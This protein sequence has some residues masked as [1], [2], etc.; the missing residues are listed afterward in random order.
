[1]PE[2]YGSKGARPVLRGGSASNGAALP[3]RLGK[4]QACV[5]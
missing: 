2:P 3:D 4:G 1:M 5:K